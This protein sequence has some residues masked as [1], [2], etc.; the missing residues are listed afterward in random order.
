MC[1]V[2]NNPGTVSFCLTHK[3]SPNL[4]LFPCVSLA[5]QEH[6]IASPTSCESLAVSPWPIR[7]LVSLSTHPGTV[8]F[9]EFL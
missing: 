1:P 9:D 7:V 8:Q 4:R 6:L 2:V 3:A 5:A